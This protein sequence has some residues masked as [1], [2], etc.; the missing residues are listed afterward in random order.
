[1]GEMLRATERAKG[2]QPYQRKSTGN[3]TSP[4]ESPTL[5]DLGLTK[6]ESAQAQQHSALSSR[7]ARRITV[8]NHV[9]LRVLGTPFLGTL[10]QSAGRNGKLKE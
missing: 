7:T 4:V 9:P 1:M 6:R 5:S 2:G 8:G 3:D 10:G